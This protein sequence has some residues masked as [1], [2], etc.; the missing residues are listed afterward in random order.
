M[1]FDTDQPRQVGIASFGDGCGEP[2]RP[3]LYT[4][5]ANLHYWIWEKILIWEAKTYRDW[6]LADDKIKK[7]TWVRPDET[8]IHT[9]KCKGI[10]NKLFC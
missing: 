2:L 4:Y 5:V 10:L 9:T 7:R 8:E 1:R 6:Q 3:G